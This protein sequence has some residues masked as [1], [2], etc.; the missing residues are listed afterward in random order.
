MKNKTNKTNK[1]NKLNIMM[2]MLVLSISIVAGCD[3]AKRRAENR[4]ADRGEYC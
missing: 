2:L 1:K 3:E 4:G